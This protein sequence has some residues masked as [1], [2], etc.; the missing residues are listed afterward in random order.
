MMRFARIAKISDP[1]SLRSRSSAAANHGRACKFNFGSTHDFKD[2]T[3]QTGGAVSGRT[4]LC[5]IAITTQRPTTLLK[6]IRDAYR[7][8]IVKM[9]GLTGDSPER[10]EAE[11]AT[12]MAIETKLASASMTRVERRDPRGNLS[13]HGM[14]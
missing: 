9:M 8:H 5:R 1:A 3:E 10:A 4:W 6:S 14:G 13:P 12:V 11:A 7:K 2:S